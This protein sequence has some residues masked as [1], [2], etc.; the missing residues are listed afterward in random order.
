VKIHCFVMVLCYSRLIYI[1][2]TRS[3]KFEQF[4]RCHENAI[5]YFENLVPEIC[6][7]DNLPTAIAEH[8]GKLTRFNP[9]FY[10]YV[11]HH[12]LSAHAC[13]QGKGHEKGRVEDGVK[14]IRSNFWKGRTFKDFEDLCT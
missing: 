3:E 12:Q 2:F 9:R 7:Y 8:V 13:N 4:I 6:W 1:E 5:R 10:A 14:Y 11:A